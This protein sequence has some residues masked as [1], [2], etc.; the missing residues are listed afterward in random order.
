LAIDLIIGE[1]PNR[2]H[3][4]AWMGSVIGW[5]EK[6]VKRTGRVPR[7]RAM[8]ALALLLPLAVFVIG[9]TFIASASR[10]WAGLIVWAAACA[11]M[12]KLVFAINT[13]GQHTAPMAEMIE[14]GDLEGARAKA[15][16]VVSRDVNA[17]DRPHLVS[18]AVE[19]VSENLVDSVISPM[20]WFGLCG[21]P[22]AVALRVVN[23]AD[24]MIGYMKPKY[25]D[26]GWFAARLDDAMHYVPARLSVPF[27]MLALA[28]MRRDWRAAWR[29]AMDQHKRTSSPNKGWPMAAAAGGLGICM[30]KTGV[31]VLGSGALV[32]DPQAIRDMIRLMRITSVLFF[33]II[34][35]P[36]FALV[37]IHVQLLLENAVLPSFLR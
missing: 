20:M 17:L 4:V 25:R 15:A 31:Y 5:G 24:A 3:P 12:L 32:D 27:I 16:M 30:E 19:T 33:L 6:R 29:T 18:C 1:P 11:V 36:L 28:I 23:T 8:G 13:L 2:F 9:F 26:V 22:G 37:G 7:D 21:L 34:L 35:L 14:R 10:H